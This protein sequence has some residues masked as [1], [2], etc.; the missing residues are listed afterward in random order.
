[1]PQE[2]RSPQSLKELAADH[3]RD[4]EESLERTDLGEMERQ[5]E[6]CR[7]MELSMVLLQQAAVIDS[8]DKLLKFAGE[9]ATKWATNMRAA[10]TKRRNDEVPRLL[11]AM[12]KRKNWARELLGIEEDD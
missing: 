9:Q 11:R 6:Q 4:A 5:I 2:D 7:H 8:D 10:T 3:M 1:M 12:E